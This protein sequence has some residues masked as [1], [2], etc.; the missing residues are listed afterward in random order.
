MVEA[1]GFFEPRDLAAERAP[2]R[3][4]HAPAHCQAQMLGRVVELALDIDEL[5]A[6]RAQF[7]QRGGV[8]R[9]HGDRTVDLINFEFEK[10]AHDPCERALGSCS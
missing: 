5:R 8:R 7:G 4:Q 1:R 10:R 2:E 3:R 6:Q 9:R